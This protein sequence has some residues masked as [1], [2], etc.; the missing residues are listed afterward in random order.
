MTS[1]LSSF[2]L[3]DNIA[4]IPALSLFSLLLLLA[5]A[6]AS[7]GGTVDPP[8]GAPSRAET[9]Q[10]GGPDVSA[11]IITTDLAV[12][13]NRMVFGLVNRDGMPVRAGEAKVQG[14][15]MIP[16]VHQ[17]PG[18]PTGEVRAQEIAKF[19]RWPVGQQ[20]V[21]ATRLMLDKP[22]FWQLRVSATGAEGQT[23]TAQGAFEVKNTSTT[24]TIG[25]PAPQSVTPTLDDVGGV[26]NLM[27]ITSADPPDP[28][29]YRLSVHTA[30]ASGR[31]LVLVF[32]TPAFCVSATCGPQVEIISQVKER[33]QDR[34][35]FIHV[36]VFKDPHL[37]QGGRPVG[38]TV[39][40]VDEWNLPSE[41]WTFVM[42]SQGLV[43]D[44]FE[45]FTVAEEIEAALAEVLAEG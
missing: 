39:P 23:I 22:G 32:S 18:Q 37:V 44:K 16:R 25:Q 27:M 38:G 8:A 1:L 36:E 3:P 42:D 13:S 40:A 20:G 31:P 6:C 24:P 30:L 28:D 29:L 4:R 17:Q 14:V 2:S 21:F 9:P 11:V 34:A 7:A 43:R 12:G 35:N 19:M 45:Q 5:A 33:F 41:P 26:A 15:Y 10:F